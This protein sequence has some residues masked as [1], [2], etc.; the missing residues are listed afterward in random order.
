MS[1]ADTA[2][3]AT[4]MAQYVVGID[5]GTS[6]CAVAVAP[7]GD[8][9]LPVAIFAIPQVVDAGVIEAKRLL[10]SFL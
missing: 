4:R 9:K 1:A 5:L 3:G 8:A 10:P 7:I 6:N 2:A